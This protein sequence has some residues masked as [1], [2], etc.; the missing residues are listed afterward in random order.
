MN[1]RNYA[2]EFYRFLF[3]LIVCIFHFSTYLSDGRAAGFP[4]DSGYLVVEF[5][6]MLSGIFLAHSAER[7]QTLTL[8]EKAEASIQYFFQRYTRLYPIICLRFSAWQ[9][10][11]F[12]SFII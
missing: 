2:I 1:K 6:F 10:S 8:K 7:K 9:P 11:E 12:W 4:F 3:S 5:F